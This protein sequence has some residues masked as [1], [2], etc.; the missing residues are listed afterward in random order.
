MDG[1]SRHGFVTSNR[2]SHQA[3]EHFVL[4][5]MSCRA[6]IIGNELLSVPDPIVSVSKAR[7]GHC[8]SSPVIRHTLLIWRPGKPS[9]RFQAHS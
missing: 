9:G 2:G 1:K 3:A 6:G 7:T 5:E 8:P 4:H